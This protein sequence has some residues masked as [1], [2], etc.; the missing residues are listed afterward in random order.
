MFEQIA[1]DTIAM[2]NTD[3]C[4]IVTIGVPTLIAGTTAYEESEVA[5]YTNL[6]IMIIRAS[7][8]A[9]E[10]LVMEGAIKK[11]QEIFIVD[12]PSI[13]GAGTSIDIDEAK[14]ILIHNSIKY[15]V[16]SSSFRTRKEYFQ[17]YVRK[18]NA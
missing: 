10:R 6:P 1:R 5:K 17:L 13:D 15:K 18:I 4:D 7:K 3:T 9:I 12:M 16:I 14:D 8:G 2:F 11:N